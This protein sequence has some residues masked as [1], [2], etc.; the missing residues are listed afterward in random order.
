M[1]H[2][3]CQYYINQLKDLRETFTVTSIM[4]MTMTV[5]FTFFKFRI[6][7]SIITPNAH[8]LHLIYRTA[9]NSH[10]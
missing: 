4:R 2:F 1:L 10:E 3:I 9:V 6:F 5:I 8:I 7:E